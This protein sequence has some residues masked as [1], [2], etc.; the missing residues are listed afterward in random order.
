MI[1]KKKMKIIPDK[2][3][4]NEEIHEIRRLDKSLWINGFEIYLDENRNIEKVVIDG[5]HPNADPDTKV[6]CLT[7]DIIGKPLENILIPMILSSIAT[8]NLNHCYF[9][10]WEKIKEIV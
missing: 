10:P 4:Y 9:R 3:I 6:L 2:L 1:I 7:D 5:E 8:Y